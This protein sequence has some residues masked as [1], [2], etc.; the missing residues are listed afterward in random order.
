MVPSPR[1]GRDLAADYASLPSS[2]FDRA[3]V[4]ETPQTKR[5]H[6]GRIAVCALGGPASTIATSNAVARRGRRTA[7]RRGAATAPPRQR[8]AAGEWDICARRRD[9]AATPPPTRLDDE[10]CSAGTRRPRSPMNTRLEPASDLGDSSA[11]SGDAIIRTARARPRSP[12]AGSGGSTAPTDEAAA[13]EKRRRTARAPRGVAAAPRLEH[14]G[15]DA[16]RRPQAFQ[17][18]A[19]RRLRARRTALDAAAF[20]DVSPRAAPPSPRRGPAPAPPSP[21]DRP[22]AAARGPAGAVAQAVAG[23][24]CPQLGRRRRRRPTPQQARLTPAA[25]TAGAYVRHG[26]DLRARGAAPRAAPP[27]QVAAIGAGTTKVRGSRRA[28]PRRPSPGRRP[29]LAGAACADAARARA[30]AEPGAHGDGGS[31]RTAAAGR[32][33]P[34]EAP[35]AGLA[36][37]AAFLAFDLPPRA[38]GVPP[39]GDEPAALN[40]VPRP[41]RPTA[42]PPRPQPQPPRPRPATTTDLARRQLLGFDLGWR[43]CSGR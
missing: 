28:P 10:P 12:H 37:D 34:A 5:A 35:R 4:R 1:T 38:G 6:M 15:L 2:H 17:S 27:P 32:S 9:A 24:P 43:T 36:R 41:L 31:N 11:L 22:A 39:P 25:L 8:A 19:R 40:A 20:L 29:R 14:G 33:V 18:P 26:L 16:A 23:R 30:I 13:P 3:A 42:A 7:A 21:G